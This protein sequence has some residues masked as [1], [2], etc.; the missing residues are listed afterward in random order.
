MALLLAQAATVRASYD[1]SVFV[2]QGN[3]EHDG[4]IPQVTLFSANDEQIAQSKSSDGPWA[5]K[6]EITT[7]TFGDGE[8]RQIHHLN[9]DAGDNAICLAWIKVN[10][11]QGET[12]TFPFYGETLKQCGARSYPSQNFVLTAE[13]E[14]RYMDCVWLNDGTNGCTDSDS[15]QEWSGFE[16]TDWVWF[17]DNGNNTGISEIGTDIAKQACDKINIRHPSDCRKRGLG[18]AVNKNDIARELITTE[19]D[20]AI[21]TCKD[22]NT[23]GQSIL[24]RSEGV[25]CDMR[26]KVI[27]P[28]CSNGFVSGCYHDGIGLAPE[29]SVTS[30]AFTSSRV[31]LDSPVAQ[32][33]VKRETAGKPLDVFNYQE[34]VECDG[35][36]IPVGPHASEQ[37]NSTHYF[38]PMLAD[39]VPYQNITSGIYIH[40]PNNQS[41]MI[42]M[43][44]PSAFVSDVLVT[45]RQEFAS[46]ARALT[47]PFASVFKLLASLV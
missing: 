8:T 6:G 10:P 31:S 18:H 12:G 28:L 44:C 7:Q 38:G 17:L 34:Q 40:F 26:T 39:P 19:R 23:H 20:I 33:L 32:N 21:S 11:S 5:Q 37:Y 36:C 2:G 24:S 25:L 3:G 14:G 13:G 45:G 47:P 41:T 43:N 16:V 29:G 46:G 22:P 9:I 30:L 27:R 42:V 4:R 35:C 1:V 15:G